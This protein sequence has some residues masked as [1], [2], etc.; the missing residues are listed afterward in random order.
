MRL[1][2]QLLV[3]VSNSKTCWNHPRITWSL[4]LWN[5]RSQSLPKE[6]VKRCQIFCQTDCF[7][8]SIFVIER[9]I[10]SSIVLLNLR[11]LDKSFK[12][13][14]FFVGTKDPV[15]MKFSE[16]KVLPNLK[17]SGNSTNSERIYSLCQ[18]LFFRRR[19]QQTLCFPSSLLLETLPRELEK[20]LK[21]V[22]KNI[23]PFCPT[24]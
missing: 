23:W 13:F 19:K 16:L 10:L 21:F 3:F 18:H 8:S 1:G 4:K 11:N 24:H 15:Q 12:P 17:T 14:Y 20:L 22:W 9:Y 5:V 6:R 2:M 7:F